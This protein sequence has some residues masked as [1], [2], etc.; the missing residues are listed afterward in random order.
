MGIFILKYAYFVIA[1]LFFSSQSFACSLMG[2]YKT[3]SGFELVQLADSII[4]AKILG[5]SS[6]NRKSNRQKIK[7]E[8]QE[9][10]KGPRPA[11]VHL[12]GYVGL[13]NSSPEYIIVGSVFGGASCS[14]RGYKEGNSVI[15]FLGK[16]N[17][18]DIYKNFGFPFARNVED[19]Q[20]KQSPWYIAVKKFI[21]IQSK[22]SKIE[23]LTA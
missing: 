15:I 1:I 22:F 16:D 19:I 23:Q 10:L 12:S 13:D 5:Q 4:V 17:E 9:V 11:K 2:S 21:S 3:P 7:I 18:S 6:A 20:S 14:R 8:I